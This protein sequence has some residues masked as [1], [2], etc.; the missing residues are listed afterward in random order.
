MLESGIT[1]EMFETFPVN[2]IERIEVIKG[3]GSVL[4]GTNAFSGVINIITEKAESTGLSV[5]G[6]VGNESAVNVFWRFKN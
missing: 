4:Y 6:L 2:I 1:S 3:P 5:N